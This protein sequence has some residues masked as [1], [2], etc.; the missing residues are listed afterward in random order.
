MSPDDVSRETPSTPEVARRAFPSDRLRLAE[1]YAELL[2]TEGV[3]RGLIGPREAPRLWDRHL[4]NC[5]LLADLI[6]PES[7]RRGHRFG[8]RPPGSGPGHRSAR[9]ADHPGRAAAAA[10]HLPHRGRRRTGARRG[11]G[12]PWASRCAARHPDLRRRHLARGRPTRPTARVVDAVGGA[13]RVAAGDEGELD[14]RRDRGGAGRPGAMGMCGAGGPRA[15][16]GRD[17]VHHGGGPGGLGRSRAGILAACDWHD[18]P[19]ISGPV[20]VDRE[21]EATDVTEDSGSMNEFSTGPD[22][23]GERGYPQVDPL[24]PQ[25]SARTGSR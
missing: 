17:R 9:P 1:R 21:A 24:H 5:A 7:T 11:R 22:Q 18:R 2:A 20:P 23:S 10:D 8:R 19:E 25:A 12:R 6:E 4:V 3:L 16:H 13:D 15:G 14:R